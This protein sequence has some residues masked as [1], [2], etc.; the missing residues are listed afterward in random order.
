MGYRRE[1]NRDIKRRSLPLL[2]ADIF[3]LQAQ[4]YAC[5]TQLHE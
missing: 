2:D 5:R 1:L 4:I 3:I